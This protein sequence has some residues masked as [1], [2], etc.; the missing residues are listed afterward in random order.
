MD[1]EETEILEDSI[2]TS[3]EIL[4][5]GIIEGLESIGTGLNDMGMW[6]AIGMVAC[7]VIYKVM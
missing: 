7:M 3:A 5:T 2:E 6:L 4:S 1:T